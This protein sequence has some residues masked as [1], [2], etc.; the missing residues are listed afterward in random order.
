MGSS[1]RLSHSSPVEL[2]SSV[3]RNEEYDPHNLSE[4]RLRQSRRL[5]D[6]WGQSG[7]RLLPAGLYVGRV[8]RGAKPADLPIV[9][10]TK[11]N[12]VINLKTAKA[13]GITV[14]PN[15][16]AIADEVIE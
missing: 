6:I 9:Q 7:R 5:A 16:L 2:I 10:S 13:L 15:I 3:T 1:L 14:P 11:F 8:L 12:L 4:P